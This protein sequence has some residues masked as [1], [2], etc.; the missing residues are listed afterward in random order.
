MKILHLINKRN[1]KTNRPWGIYPMKD[2]KGVY[3]SCCWD[4]PLEKSK[5]LI[6]GMIFFH[7]TKSDRSH[8]GGVVKDVL[9]VNLNDTSDYPFIELNEDEDPQRKDR[10]MFVFQV[11]QEGRE[12]KWRGK[13][14]SMSWTSGIIDEE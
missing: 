7:L 13:D 4:F 14:H 8:L 3:Y 1:P 5:E 9:P 10:V 2:E 12:Q 11:T 6:G